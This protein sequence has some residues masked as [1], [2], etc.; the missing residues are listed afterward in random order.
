MIHPPSLRDGRANF[1]TVKEVPPGE[2]VLAGKFFLYDLLI[3]ILVD[4]GPLHNFMS[5]A[6]AQNAKLTLYATQVP[7]LISTPGGRV[8]ADQ[9]V[10]KIPLE[11]VRRVF[12]TSLI[13]LEGQGID[14]VLGMNW[15][16]MHQVVLDIATHLAHLDSPIFS[17]VSLQLPP[18]AHLQAG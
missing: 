12:P 9:M 10:H 14:G 11:L 17:K 8:V 1:T 2:E 7:Y 18:I 3:I 5:L 13:I 15:M 4:S 16:K 6:C